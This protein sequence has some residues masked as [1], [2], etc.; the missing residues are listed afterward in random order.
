MPDR[1]TVRSFAEHGTTMAIYL[2]AA[3]NKALQEELIAGG[4]PEDTPCIIGYRVSWPDQ[5]MWRTTLGDLSATMREHQLWKH[6]IVLVG[7]ALA[8]T[9]V[10]ARSHL[11]HPGFPHEYRP[12]EI[13]AQERLRSEGAGRVTTTDE[14]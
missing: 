9:P 5:Q 8:D 13:E 12:A 11:Y 14:P 7:P 2:S 6:T 4:Y 3:R 10:E 1:E